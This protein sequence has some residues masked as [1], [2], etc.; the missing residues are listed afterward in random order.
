MTDDTWDEFVAAC[1]EKLA[2]KQSEFFVRFGLQSANVRYDL[3]TEER[4]LR[5]QLSEHPDVVSE[6]EIVGSLSIVEGTWLW[7]WGNPWIADLL[8]Q[9]SQNVRQIGTERQWPRLANPEWQATQ[10]DAEQMVAVAAEITMAEAFW[11]D[12]KPDRDYYFLLYNTKCPH[13]S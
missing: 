4:L 10:L 9:R 8:K 5:F 12:R 3:N 1:Y 6:I 7:A 11:R 2:A 13:S